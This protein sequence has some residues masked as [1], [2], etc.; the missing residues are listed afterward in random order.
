M[1]TVVTGRAPPRDPSLLAPPGPAIPR[2]PGASRLPPYS[3]KAPPASLAAAS[4]PPSP[5]RPGPPLAPLSLPGPR[6]GAGRRAG[7]GPGLGECGPQASL[8]GAR[9]ARLRALRAAPGSGWGSEPA[10]PRAA[11]L[12][13]RGGDAGSD[14][15]GAEGGSG[16]GG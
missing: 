6:R 14:G 3:L 5:G 8:S 12:Q 16:M 2:P 9:P 15:E 7:S 13:V 11:P 1:K 10:A 4:I